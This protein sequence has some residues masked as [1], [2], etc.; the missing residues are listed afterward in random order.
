MTLRV[1][2]LVSGGG[3]T[4]LN[5]AERIE[6]RE[7]DAAI[8]SVIASRGD[9]A[10]VGRS[11]DSGLDV[12][13]IEHRGQPAIV[14]S[15]RVFDL[16]QQLDVDLVLMAGYLKLLPIPS[17]WLGRVM[18]IHPSLIPSFC[19]AGF[20]GRKVHEAVLA[21]GCKVSG[22]T[23][24]FADNEYDAGPIILQRVVPV[25]DADTPD[26]L[27]AR[28]FAAECEAYPDAIGLFAAGRLKI[29]GRV[30]KILSE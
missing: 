29:D 25:L 24:H 3:T 18:N 10:A 28:V 27:A 20:H 9:I 16:C 6:R 15:Q 4:V 12:A 22:C 5:L 17:D 1:A 13:V 26:S 19:G 30:V 21:R 7:L 11:R 23:V 14:T 8:V 2:A